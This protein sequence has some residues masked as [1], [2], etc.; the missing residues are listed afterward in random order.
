MISGDLRSAPPERRENIREIE[1]DV[2]AY[3]RAVLVDATWISLVGVGP[4]RLPRSSSWL[5]PTGPVF[6]PTLMAP[7]VLLRDCVEDSSAGEEDVP[8]GVYRPLG[9]GRFQASQEA[10]AALE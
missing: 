4:F 9:N 1:P 7:C 3:P 6:C 2:K 10:F 8:K 5:P